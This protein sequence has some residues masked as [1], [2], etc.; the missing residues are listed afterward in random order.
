MAEPLTPRQLRAQRRNMCPAAPRKATRKKPRAF[1]KLNFE[2]VVR[3]ALRSAVQSGNFDGASVPP[4]KVD[5]VKQAIVRGMDNSQLLPASRDGKL[6]FVVDINGDGTVS[7][8]QQVD[9]TTTEFP[10]ILRKVNNHE[11]ENN[12]YQDSCF[13][14]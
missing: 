3:A 2:E 5:G 1:R 9:P 14:M 12:L 8:T 6:I 7:G 13:A 10:A 4:D 11:Q